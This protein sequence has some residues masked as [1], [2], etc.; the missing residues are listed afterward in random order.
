MFVHCLF[1]PR[2]KKQ[3]GQK[4]KLKQILNRLEW[5]YLYHFSIPEHCSHTT[6]P[7][8]HLVNTV[9][10]KLSVEQFDVEWSQ[11]LHDGHLAIL[12][13]SPAA[14]NSI[15]QVSSENR[16]TTVGGVEVDWEDS[17]FTAGADLSNGYQLTDGTVGNHYPFCGIKTTTDV[18]IYVVKMK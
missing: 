8:P 18:V 3:T 12:Q 13:H 1:T 7:W 15:T 17:R 9:I 2:Q 4:N 10:A 5:S 16:T 11:V 14:D 6:I